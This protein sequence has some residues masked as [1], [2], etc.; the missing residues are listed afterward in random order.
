MTLAIMTNATRVSFR[1]TAVLSCSKFLEPFELFLTV[2]LCF[3]DTIPWSKDL[4]TSPLYHTHFRP[5]CISWIPLCCGLKSQ[6]CHWICIWFVQVLHSSWTFLRRHMCQCFVQGL[7]N[8]SSRHNWW[9]KL[10][11]LEPTPRT[12]LGW[13]VSDCCTRWRKSGSWRKSSLWLHRL[14]SPPLP[15]TSELFRFSTARS[16]P[17]LLRRIRGRWRPGWRTGRWSGCLSLFPHGWLL[18]ALELSSSSVL[19]PRLKK[20][21]S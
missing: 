4:K 10:G 17:G 15:S 16:E 7:Y 3:M 12:P 20:I 2:N 11:T 13:S 5:H 21:Q 6:F 14:S 19:T 1:F 18:V 9:S 8:A